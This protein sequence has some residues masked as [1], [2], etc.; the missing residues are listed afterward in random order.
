MDNID[1]QIV[2][3]LRKNGRASLSLLAS[4]LKLSRATIRKHIEGL[5]NSGD[6]VGFTVVLREDAAHA[7]VRGL[8]MIAI[9]GRGTERVIRQLTSMAAVDALHTTNGKWDLVAELSANSLEELD[10]ILRQIRLLDGIATSETNLLLA[11]RKMVRAPRQPQG[12]SSPNA[13]Q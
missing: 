9:E 3:A 4:D 8:M 1:Q 12:S 5:S 2:A 10:G 7:P 13:P 11:T 6:I